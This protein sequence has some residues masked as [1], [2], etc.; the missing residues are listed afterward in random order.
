MVKSS[1]PSKCLKFEVAGS[2]IKRKPRK[3]YSKVK[4]RKL[5]DWAYSKK[6]AKDRKV[7]KSFIKISV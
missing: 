5:E 3:P 4:G 6:Q 7:W 1:W 2:L